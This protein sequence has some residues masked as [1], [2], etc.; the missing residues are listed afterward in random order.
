MHGN[1]RSKFL[2]GLTVVDLKSLEP[3]H[4]KLSVI[5][6]PEGGIIDDTIITNKVLFFL[7]NQQ[8]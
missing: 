5:T 4:A 6:N 3:S 1:D 8:K 2:E 7:H